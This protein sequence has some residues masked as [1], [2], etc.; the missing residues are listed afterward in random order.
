M[1]K[2]P[3]PTKNEKFQQVVRHFLSTPHTPHKPLGKPKPKKKRRALRASVGMEN[4][5]R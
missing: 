3:D 5:D 4:A 2:D 1:A